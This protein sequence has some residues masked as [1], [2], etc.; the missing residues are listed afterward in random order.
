MVAVAHRATVVVFVT[1]LA[2]LIA[3]VILARRRPRAVAL[4][5]TANIAGALVSLAM[6]ELFV[7]RAG[8][9]PS[10]PGGRAA[11]D[12]VLETMAASLQ[13][14][15]IFLAGVGVVALL[16]S[17]IILARSPDRGDGSATGRGVPSPTVG[18]QPAS[19]PQTLH[20]EV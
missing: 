16:G 17:A 13:R 20:L 8:R 12:A 10:E 4:L 1:S 2:S 7:D 19:E 3:A 18:R 14:S 5:A 15:L 9:I 11:V 6:L